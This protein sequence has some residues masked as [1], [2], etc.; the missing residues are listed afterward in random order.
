VQLLLGHRRLESTIRYLGGEVEDA[1]K[2][3]EQ[4]EVWAAAGA[5]STGVK[6]SDTGGHNTPTPPA[7]P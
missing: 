4:T 5:G 3:S 6:F 1:L 2:T 7:L